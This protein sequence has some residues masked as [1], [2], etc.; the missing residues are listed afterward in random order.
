MPD[1]EALKQFIETEIRYRVQADGGELRFVDFQD[2]TVTLRLQ[3][4]CSICPTAGGCMK[5]WLVKELSAFMQRPIK[6]DYIRTRPYF[7][8]R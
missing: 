4:E 6:V 7:W 1:T 2:D 5:S 8:D 3:G